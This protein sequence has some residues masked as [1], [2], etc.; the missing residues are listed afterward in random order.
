MVHSIQQ[1]A[2]SWIIW[3][4]Q[5]Y[6]LCPSYA[7]DYVISIKTIDSV[8][9][10][11]S[12]KSSREHQHYILQRAKPKTRNDTNKNTKVSSMKRFVDIRTKNFTHYV[13]WNHSST[14]WFW[15]CNAYMLKIPDHLTLSQC[16]GR[17]NH[18]W[19]SR[20]LL[21][22]QSRRIILSVVNTSKFVSF[23]Q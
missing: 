17:K 10:F 21:D 3:I 20:K 2:N 15:W 14:F 5:Q 8:I 22:K 16:Q 1:E 7:P 18:L 23:S 12:F 9:T 6:H 11:Y 13:N 19:G 4:L